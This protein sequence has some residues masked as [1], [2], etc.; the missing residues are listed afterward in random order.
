MT[1]L[2]VN[3]LPRPAQG[4]IQKFF[5]LA[6]LQSAFFT[7]SGTFYVLFVL[8]Q[9]GFEALG[10]LLA[11]SFIVQAVL[12]YP[13]G[14]LGDWIG[15]RWVLTISFLSYGLSYGLLVFTN[16]F[17]DLILVYVL[18][19]FAGAQ[20]SG[21]M[22]SWFDNNYK[23]ATDNADPKRETYQLFQGKFQMFLGLLWGGTFI[24]G[25]LVATLYYRGLV[26]AFQSIG[27]LFLALICL[28][29][30]R[31]LPGI[32]K[33]EVSVR[34]YFIILGES[35]KFTFFSKYAFFITLSVCIASAAFA[36]WGQMILF[37]MYYGYTG[38]DLG[39]AIF[40]FF[41]WLSASSTAAK[42][43]QISGRLNIRKWL[44]R[45]QLYVI[46]G[47]FGVF[48]LLFFILPFDKPNFLGAILV[49]IIFFF[50]DAGVNIWSILR[51]RLFL[52]MIPDNIRNSYYSLLPTLTLIVSAPAV[53][54]GGTLIE[55]YG[56]SFTLVL[57]MLLG[58]LSC[59]FLFAG[60]R[61]LPKGTLNGEEEEQ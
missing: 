29:F 57:M 13:S 27:M 50:A 48:A 58:W 11:V 26:F 35:A 4:L 52:D 22:Q 31:N 61:L 3:T 9:V 59:F 8:D 53:L 44:P 14:V 20:N 41:A 43:G 21:A 38:S 1:F 49:L 45:M 40:R 17:T 39:A 5:F 24:I 10:I 12:D 30:V 56:T 55:N 42:A 16:S 37:P 7:V 60:M 34:N 47:Y 51:Q 54:V 46:M 6:S 28:T 36:I 18:A 19:A 23:I 2:R 33:P 25:G 32:P 15:H